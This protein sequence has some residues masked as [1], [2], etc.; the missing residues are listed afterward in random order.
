MM[1]APPATRTSPV[2]DALIVS[3]AVR[4]EIERMR[5][6]GE[7]GDGYRM[8]SSCYVC[9]EVESRD[10]VNKL[11]AAGLTNREITECCGAINSR[12]RDN[13]DDR[14]IKARNVWTHRTE[15]F[16]VDKPAQAMLREIAER[17]A[18]E[19]NRDFVNG[20]AHIVT[21]YA[22][23]EGAMVKGYASIT[24][25]AT[26]ISVKDTILAAVKLDEL[27]NRDAGSKTIASLMYKMDRIIG[28][29][30]EIV[31]EQYHQAILDRIDDSAPQTA[32]NAIVESVAE[33]VD[34]TVKEFTPDTRPDERDAL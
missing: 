31:P 4:D 19:Q 32:I 9:C 17:R 30:R 18:A 12:R 14:V 28:A 3:D 16:N 24:D 15:H 2:S 33:S 25:E 10:L 1:G 21:P 22:V 6:E 7:L 29:I 23:L 27:T 34:Q 5:A 11:I 8:V 13:N 20:I 26:Q